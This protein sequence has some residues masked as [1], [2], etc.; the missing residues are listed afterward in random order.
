MK[1]TVSLIILCLAS[2]RPIPD[3]VSGPDTGVDGPVESL[4]RIAF[5]SRGENLNIGIYLIFPDGSGQV[6]LSPN[7][8]SREPSWAPDGQSIIYATKRLP[9][10]AW[11]LSSI[12]LSTGIVTN[13]TGGLENDRAPAWAPERTRIAFERSPSGSFQSDIFVA[14]A[15]GSNSVAL[16]NDGRDNEAPAWSPDGTKIA[17][18][19]ETD[20]SQSIDVINADGSGRKTLVGGPGIWAGAP[21]WSPDG[22]QILFESTLHQDAIG[23]SEFREYD[24][25]IMNADG[26]NIQRVT[27]FGRS[28]RMIRDPSWSPDGLAFAFESID[29][30]PTFSNSFT[31]RIWTVRLDGQNLQEIPVTT[32]FARFP[33]W[34]P[35]Q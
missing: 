2:C 30:S 35:V 11:N 5:L 6:A 27:V 29:A 13:I 18:H 22:T 31:F 34:S 14:H 7:L 17:F 4:G 12:D 23:P 8:P 16:T 15:N 21:A 10:S 33:R 28:D 26:S 24:I 32:G 9:S 1:A 19:S 25:Y 3:D 20:T